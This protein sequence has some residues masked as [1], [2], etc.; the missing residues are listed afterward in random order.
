M[1]SKIKAIFHRDINI[2]ADKRNVSWSIKASPYPQTFPRECIE[3]A[4]ERGA[5][6]IVQP[7]KRTKT[8]IEPESEE[9]NVTPEADT[10]ETASESGLSPTSN[11]DEKE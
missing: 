8:A 9:S 7:K 3:Q 4:V 10:G 11:A 2:R 6:T 1:K 5:A